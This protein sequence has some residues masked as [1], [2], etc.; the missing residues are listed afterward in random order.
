MHFLPLYMDEQDYD[1]SYSDGEIPYNT[2][3]MELDGDDIS[4]S[5]ESYESEHPDEDSQIRSPPPITS[6]PLVQ[7]L[8]PRAR[9]LPPT[10]EDETP[11]VIPPDNGAAAEPAEPAAEIEKP[12]ATA[13]SQQARAATSISFSKDSV[14]DDDGQ[15]CTICFEQWTNMSDHRLVSLRCGHLFGRSCITRWLKGQNRCPQCNARARKSEIRNIYAR[16]VKVIDSSER[17]K[18]LEDLVKETE[19]R[20]KAEI[21][22]TQ[23]RLKLMLAEQECERLKKELMEATRL[24]KEYRSSSKTSSSTQAQKPTS[25]FRLEKCIDIAKLGGCRIVDSSSLLGM[26]LVSQ[27]STNELFPGYGFRKVSTYEMKPA[28]FVL[29]HQKPIRDMAFHVNDA[30]VLTAALDKSL[31][32]TNVLSNSVVQTYTVESDVWSCAWDSDDPVYFYGGLKT[33]EVYVFDIR[34]TSRHVYQL[35]RFGAKTP[36]VSLQYLK[37]PMS[38]SPRR[39]GPIVGKLSDCALQ[40]KTEIPGFYTIVPLPSLGPLT[41][42]SS[43]G[44]GHFL[45]SCRPSL[46]QPCVSHTLCEFEASRTGD[47]VCNPLHTVLGGKT[48]VQLTR[49]KLLAHPDKASSVLICAGDED[50][51]GALI[52]DGS[53]G[54]CMDHLRTDTPVLDF[55]GLKINSKSYLTALTDK[56]LRLYSWTAA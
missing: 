29:V 7:R 32:I 35:P 56:T 55:A 37:S 34:V 48:Q 18:A 2:E 1:D 3:N 8:R 22:A 40:Q 26:I 11:P 43:E 47:L 53:S 36:A 12:A 45:V 50:A 9:P 15:I 39:C 31:K 16:A 20:R 4:E 46:K 51:R 49:S 5:D 21:S 54:N 27:P 10:Q 14:G 24:L 41:S 42:L 25:V 33:G 52:W 6:N 30:L 17:D 44:S 13:N 23:E 19:L 38:V 28:E